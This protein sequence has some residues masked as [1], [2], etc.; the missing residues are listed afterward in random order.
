MYNIRT[1]I[2]NGTEWARVNCAFSGGIVGA[3]SFYMLIFCLGVD[4]EA[5]PF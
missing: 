1:F 4:P 3:T 2:H 5:W